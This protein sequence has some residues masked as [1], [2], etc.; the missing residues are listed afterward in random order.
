MNAIAMIGR[1]MRQ[2]NPELPLPWVNENIQ[3]LAM[4]DPVVQDQQPDVVGEVAPLTPFPDTTSAP[5][6]D[7]STPDTMSAI[8]GVD[9]S[10]SSA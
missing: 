2:Q 9:S 7:T 4:I 1:C 3:R 5:P 10:G 6:T 8:D